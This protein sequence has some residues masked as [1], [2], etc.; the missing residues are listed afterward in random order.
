[1]LIDLHCH[2][3]YSHD[4]YL[5][6]DDLFDR[7]IEMGLDGVCITEHHSYEA[8]APIMHRPRPHNLLVLRG[9]E[10]STDYGHLLVYGV[11]DDSWNL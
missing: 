9:L 6:P 3:K 1:M 10:I 11:S 8:S 2:T 7:A 5:E 4:N